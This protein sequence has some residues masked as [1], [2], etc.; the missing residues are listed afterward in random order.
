[1]KKGNQDV[2]YAVPLWKGE[3]VVV[4]RGNAKKPRFHIG[5][6][7]AVVDEGVDRKAVVV[8]G[9]SIEDTPYPALTESALGI[10][11]FYRPKNPI[12]KPPAGYFEAGRFPF[13]IAKDQ[14]VSDGAVDRWMN[15][16]AHK[17][18]R[19]MIR[20]NKS[21]LVDV[22]DEEAVEKEDEAASKTSQGVV[23]HVPVFR[24][25]FVIVNR[26]NAKKPLFHIGKVIAIVDEGVDRKVVV[27]FGGGI[28]DTSYPAFTESAIG[29][30]GFYRPKNPISKP[31][32][33][34]FEADQFPS[35]VDKKKWVSDGAINRWM[36]GA[37]HKDARAIAQASKRWLVDVHD[38]EVVDERQGEKVVGSRSSDASAP[39]SGIKVS[40]QERNE[41]EANLVSLS[42]LSY[43][44]RTAEVM[45]AQLKTSIELRESSDASKLA[46]A[47]K[48]AEQTIK[49][50]GMEAR[51]I[52][53]AHE[54]FFDR[55]AAR[56]GIRL[57]QAGR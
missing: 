53:R 21:W 26:G 17:D 19:A 10:V 43:V 37:A 16:S 45:L 20:E 25:R 52:A 54:D 18:A 47:V 32:A 35:A 13:V 34:Y 15:E 49:W 27:S 42:Q 36:K 48:R 39:D 23:Y 44:R 29:V 33:G 50:A 40:V 7:A 3:F 28:G 8:F 31:P 24:G 46:A 22:D 51:R 2:V 5:K 41:L 30:V 12:S 4:N 56:Q 57:R 1:M 6:I 11:G 38:E 9:G 55:K 14:W